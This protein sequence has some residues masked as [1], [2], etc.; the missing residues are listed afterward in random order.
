MKKIALVG[1]PNVGKSTLY[2]RLTKSYDAVTSDQ[3]G[4][5]RDIRVGV[6]LIGE[7][8][9]L[10]VDTGGLEGRDELFC[11]VR[12]KAIE[13]AKDA[14][15]VLFLVDAKR[16]PDSD[17]KK[18]FFELQRLNHPIAL[19]LNKSDNQGL[20]D[21]YYAYMGF[22]AEQTF[23]I[24][25]AHKLGFEP[26][27]KWLA[28]MLEE[29]ILE[30]ENITN[31]TE[32][33]DEA[34]KTAI[35]GRPNV[36]KSALLNALVGFERSVVSPQ[37]GT[38]VDPVNESVVI[39]SRRI[40]F[41]DTAGIRKRSRIEGIERFAFERTEQ[42]LKEADVALLVL[43]ASEDFCEL[44]E[45]IA[46][47]AD[48]HKTAVIVVLNKLDIAD[49]QF[50]Q[51]EQELRNRFLFLSFAPII[52]LSA[53]TKKRVSK[54]YEMIFKAYENYSRRVQTSTLNE[55]VRNAVEKHH[56]P[57]DR[58]KAV[59]IYYATQFETKPPKIALIVNRPRSIHF[60][61]LRYITNQIRQAVDFEGAPIVIEVRSRKENQDT[62]L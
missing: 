13:A 27:K 61:Y 60:S 15:I 53:Q 33:G 52:S 38:T 46:G 37:A 58:G 5:T 3:A 12:Q 49:K 31:A 10:I 39:D 42:M 62:I 34:I 44:D 43:D 36:G 55:I 23:A 29:G 26:M 20:S 6:A 25:C 21:Q 32:V 45:R 18:L 47:L 41:V 14:D 35:I 48:K 17:D 8:T 30:N 24:S 57:S 22:G 2:N 51:L 50:A 16:Y 19:V 28:S 7:K 56:L 1:R 4:T 11:K 54:L 59:K 9:A 40:V